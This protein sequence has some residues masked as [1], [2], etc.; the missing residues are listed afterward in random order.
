MVEV[1]E[2]LAAAG[3]RFSGRG[4]YRLARVINPAKRLS[5]PLQAMLL[6]AFASVTDELYQAD[7]S[8]HWRGRPDYFVGVRGLW[9]VFNGDVL[10]G[11]AAS[12][13][14]VEAGERILYIDNLNLRPS[15]RP[16][17][18][19]LTI[20]G[21]LVFE[22]LKESF[23][24]IGRPMSV[25]F[26]TQNPNVYRLGFTVLPE[27]MA[28]RLRGAQPRDPARSRRVLEAMANRLS[29]GRV[30]DPITSVIKGAYAGRLYGRPLTQ[31]GSSTSGLVRFW[32]ENVDVEQGDAVLIAVSPTHAEVRGL[33][34]RYL[35][36]LAAVSWARYRHVSGAVDNARL[37]ACGEEESH[38]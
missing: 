22:M 20:G 27:A 26:R 19:Q 30:Y 32:K 8:F 38:P 37:Q 24:I 4:R 2:Q 25:V 1:I 18:G 17:V 7:T 13:Y 23:P 15:A 28:P 35:K 3:I 36:I 14:F 12:R 33:V 5:K 9:M 21:M 34:Y 16:V 29:P 10:S 6:E 31:S 11:F